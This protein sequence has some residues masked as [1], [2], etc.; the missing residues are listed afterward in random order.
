MQLG[1]YA[2]LTGRWY[3]IVEGEPRNG[4]STVGSAAESA[5]SS[6]AGRKGAR[7]ESEGD[8]LE[9]RNGGERIRS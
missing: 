4:I 2:P 7:G 5:H 3:S 1:W 6:T 8:G 9:G